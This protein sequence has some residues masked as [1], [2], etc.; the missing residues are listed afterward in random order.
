MSLPRFARRST[1]P[2]RVLPSL[3]TLESRAV[4]AILTGIGTG[5]LAYTAAS[6]VANSLQVEKVGVNLFKFTDPAEGFSKTVLC[7]TGL[8]NL[9]IQTGDLNDVVKIGAGVTP[10]VS[11][12]IKLGTGGDKA[13]VPLSAVATST[14][15]D[16]GGNLGDQLFVVDDLSAASSHT[17]HLLKNAIDPVATAPINFVGF[18]GVEYDGS[19]FSDSV[20][21]ISTSANTTISTGDGD[22][23]VLL[24]RD[25]ANNYALDQILGAV[26]F[27]GGNGA[28]S[29]MVDDQGNPYSDSYTIASNYCSG[30]PAASIY[31]DDT[32]TITL[33]TTYDFGANV[34]V[35][36]LN[37]GQTAHVYTGVGFNT[38]RVG[39]DGIGNKF[40]KGTLNL[41]GT[42]SG[43]DILTLDDSDGTAGRSIGMTYNQV[44]GKWA[45]TFYLE[46][47][48]V[49]SFQGNLVHVLCGS[50]NDLVNASGIPVG[51]VMDIDGGGGLDSLTGSNVANTFVI[52]GLDQGSIT[53]S[54]TASFKHVE[55]L[56][57]SDGA[58]GYPDYG[59]D[60]FVFKPGGQM[61][62][63][64][65]GRNGPDT[66]D[67]SAITT[68]V[69]VNLTTGNASFVGGLVSNVEN[70]I[71][72]A[73]N[74]IL[75]GNALGN[76]LEGNG[77]RDVIIGGFGADT[78]RGGDDQDLEIGGA[79]VHDANP[80]A[81]STMQWIWTSADSYAVRVAT[82][83]EDS[84]NGFA[85]LGA[86]KLLNDAAVDTLY[87]DGSTDLFFASLDD[88]TPDW[89]WLFE[90]RMTVA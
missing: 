72:G 51:L 44:Y 36:S 71:G 2:R 22:D 58:P 1:T 76:T 59:A 80:F 18:K 33:L 10:S 38:V 4:P 64:I 55:N 84:P 66:L 88:L 47:G 69:Y 35:N 86:G 42:S 52:N 85:L 21:V 79:T 6:G 81:L 56:L 7:P 49:N 50:G 24:G 83:T 53:M 5:S 77:G 19:A 67:Y 46:G 90:K 11:L 39:A 61:S 65:N 75:V 57:G 54:G 82:L 89:A 73:G 68:D 12:T 9:T 25:A 34:Q 17:V 62:G 29:I 70:A 8:A 30:G 78:I 31:H 32:E 27:E 43:Y 26:T 14:S 37:A 63:W 23:F 87:G 41:F 48:Q 20:R 13:T 28:D 16:G 45:E 3:T 60:L 40:L 74:D 15:V